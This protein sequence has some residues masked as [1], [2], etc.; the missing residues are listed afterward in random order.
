MTC[1]YC[2]ALQDDDAVTRC[3]WTTMRCTRRSWTTTRC[4][5]NCSRTTRRCCCCC[6]DSPLQ[7]GAVQDE[8]DKENS[9]LEQSKLQGEWTDQK[10]IF[11]H[12]QKL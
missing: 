6:L 11:N 2:L 7:D 4:N 5:M 1:C 10:T 12:L 8:A 9:W 3:S